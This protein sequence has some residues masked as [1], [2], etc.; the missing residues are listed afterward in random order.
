MKGRCHQRP[1][2][3]G[4]SWA[5]VGVLG[6]GKLAGVRGDSIRGIGVV[7]VSRWIKDERV[8]A[9]DRKH[10]AQWGDRGPP[11]GC[12]LGSLDAPTDL[13]PARWR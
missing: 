9:D 13:T 7:G 12:R 2:V 5:G 4:E 1:G 6:H 8:R 11:A 10:L 3:S